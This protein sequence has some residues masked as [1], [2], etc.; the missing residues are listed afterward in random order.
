MN[1]YTIYMH[2]NKINGKIYIG[3]TSQEPKKRWNNGQGYIDCSRFYNAII[4]YGWDNCEQI[5]VYQDVSQGQANTVEEQLI[6]QYKTQDD[7]YGYNIKAGGNNKHHTEETKI[8]IGKANSIALKGNTWSEHHR[9][10]ISKMFSGKG[11]PFYG[12]HHTEETKKKISQSRKGKRAGEDH[13]MYGKCHTKEELEK[14][15]KNR[16]SK[17]GKQVLCIETGE[18]FN[19]MMDAARKYNL[20]TSAGIGQCCIGKAKSAGKHPLTKEPLHWKFI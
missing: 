4:K 8:K 19:C 17:G 15:S 7:R 11:N 12:K 16:Q 1:N 6:K 3:Q 9:Q 20:K 18:I 13:P 2:K 14:M 5:M 10:I